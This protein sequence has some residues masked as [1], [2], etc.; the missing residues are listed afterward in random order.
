M[1]CGQKSL[2]PKRDA[3]GCE[4]VK[5]RGRAK[6]GRTSKDDLFLR[7]EEAAVNGE[8]GEADL[9]YAERQKSNTLIHTISRGK[10]LQP[11]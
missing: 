1:S 2:P 9:A 10:C 3:A 11:T 5:G 6:G 7:V 4:S 8:K